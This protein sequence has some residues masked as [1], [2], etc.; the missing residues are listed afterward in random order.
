MKTVLSILTFTTDGNT[1]NNTMADNTCGDK[2]IYKIFPLFL[3]LK[4]EFS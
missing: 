3:V 1:G 2:G 4:D